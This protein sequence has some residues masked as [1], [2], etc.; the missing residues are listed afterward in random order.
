MKISHAQMRALRLA[1]R[2]R[3]DHPST[4]GWAPCG[5]GQRISIR[6]RTV[7]KLA[8]DGLVE[9]QGMYMFRLTLA[10]CMVVAADFAKDKAFAEKRRAARQ[11][12]AT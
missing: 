6:R 8:R 2:I 11:L 4:D 1:Y 12:D 9:M 10:G 5:G 3:E 7:R